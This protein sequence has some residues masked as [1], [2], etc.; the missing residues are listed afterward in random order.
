MQTDE[1][2]KSIENVKEG[3]KVLSFDEATGRNEYQ[4]LTETF[5]RWADDV[6][7]LKVEGEEEPIGVTSEH[8]FFVRVHGAR[9]DTSGEGG[10]EWLETWQ[11]RAG[12]E[13]R[14]AS[15]RWAR[16]VSNL[17]KGEGRVYNFTVEKN[18]NYFVG[19]LRLLTHNNCMTADQ[20]ALKELVDEATNG[21]RKPLSVD[22]AETVLDLAKEVN[23]GVRAKPGDVSSP[24][25]WKIPGNPPHILVPGVGSGH[26]PVMPGVKPRP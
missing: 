10:G 15:G 22:D 4:T 14:L 5:S 20:R 21:G 2:L 6:W 18:H 23:P 24:S 1:G 13:I 12:D 11:I 3:D 25:N 26:I 16:V 8:P 19:Q 17:P 7:E 9:S